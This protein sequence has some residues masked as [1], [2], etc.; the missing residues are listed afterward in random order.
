MHHLQS[1]LF[2][3]E[4]SHQ[5]QISAILLCFQA[6]V[7]EAP[8]AIDAIAGSD[9]GCQEQDD[10]MHVKLQSLSNRVWSTSIQVTC[11]SIVCILLCRWVHIS[12]IV[13]EQVIKYILLTQVVHVCVWCYYHGHIKLYALSH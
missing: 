2:S 7:E 13:I 11:A 3:Y 12:S 8:A 4:Y 1:L 5:K 6:S 9:V 10:C